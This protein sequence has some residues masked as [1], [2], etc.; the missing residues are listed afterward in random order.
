[1]TSVE[2]QT[3]RS[4]SIH[5]AAH[6]VAGWTFGVPTKDVWLD[7]IP[8]SGG[9]R[10]DYARQPLDGWAAGT[11]AIIGG[12][13]QEVLCGAGKGI[14]SD[15]DREL[16]GWGFNL[17]L[18][19][20]PYKRHCSLVGRAKAEALVTDRLAR[21]AK[22]LVQ[23]NEVP[24]EWLGQFLADRRRLS[25]RDLAGLVHMPGGRFSRWACLYDKP[26]PLP[27]QPAVQEAFIEYDRRGQIKH[28]R[29]VNWSGGIPVQ[30]V[31][32]VRDGGY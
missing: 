32:H 13:A 27:P 23:A 2:Q 1:M 11:M 5:E 28:I 8:M 4:A 3:D 16:L 6:V 20:D 25:S 12:V 22:A 17:L 7:A 30:T 9:T 15:T 21:E 24:I 26:K 19:A 29:K 10:Y 14:V 18:A 31:G